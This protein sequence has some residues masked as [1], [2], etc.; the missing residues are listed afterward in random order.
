MKY[1]Y[2]INIDELYPKNNV[3][4]EVNIIKKKDDLLK[5]K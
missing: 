5:M 4:K 1:P 2:L 3:I